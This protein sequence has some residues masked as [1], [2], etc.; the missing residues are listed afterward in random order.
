MHSQKVMGDNYI[1]FDRPYLLHMDDVVKAVRE[2]DKSESEADKKKG[3]QKAERK[4]YTLAI[5]GLPPT[6]DNAKSIRMLLT[7]ADIMIEG[8]TMQTP[9][10]KVEVIKQGETVT[11]KLM[12]DDKGR[13]ARAHKLM[14]NQ[15]AK[16][17]S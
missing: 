8:E 17:N 1:R 15:D 12:G 5:S 3:A 14:A 2:L 4:E 9:Y 11:L 7:T 6:T 13:M 16:L 10:N